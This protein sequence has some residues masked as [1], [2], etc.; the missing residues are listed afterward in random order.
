MKTLLALLLTFLIASAQSYKEFAKEMGYET[1]YQKALKKAKDE[2]KELLVVMIT[3]NCPWCIRFEKTTLSD[4]TIDEL[5]KRSYIPLILNKNDG[6]FPPY[7]NTP[8][9][10]T[11]Y[12]ID[13]KD[14][15]SDY[16]R[17]GFMGKAEFLELFEEL[18]L[19]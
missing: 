13:P 8:I 9:V 18:E 1:N 12:I 14:E 5:I 16:E 2:N 4:K 15:K 17:M 6:G 19:E 11:T 7:L 3:N 10:P